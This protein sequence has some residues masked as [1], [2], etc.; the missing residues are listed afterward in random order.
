MR[1]SKALVILLATSAIFCV[2]LP[3]ANAVLGDG[4]LIVY[5]DEDYRGF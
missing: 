2:V 3:F 1:L 5:W 4:E